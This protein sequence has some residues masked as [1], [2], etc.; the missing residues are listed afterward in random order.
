M[1]FNR[2][3]SLLPQNLART[4]SDKLDL[5]ISVLLTTCQTDPSKLLISGVISQ[6]STT[7]PYSFKS[8]SPGSSQTQFIIGDC[9]EWGSY[10]ACSKT[11]GGGVQVRTRTCPENSLN[12]RKQK[13]HCNDELCPGQSMYHCLSF[14][15][16]LKSV[17]FSVFLILT[18]LCVCVVFFFTFFIAY[19]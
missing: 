10:G 5:F 18:T 2:L 7:I 6:I 11:C 12:L 4:Q 14:E 15:S 17:S 3:V 8:S 13:K 19:S 9:G 1:I 16:Y